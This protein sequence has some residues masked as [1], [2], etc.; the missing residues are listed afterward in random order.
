MVTWHFD[1]VCQYWNH[2]LW[3]NPHFR[4]QITTC[5]HRN[6]KFI[7]FDIQISNCGEMQISN[8]ESRP[9]YRKN[10]LPCVWCGWDPVEFIEF[11]HRPF[12]LGG[13]PPS[14][15]PDAWSAVPGTTTRAGGMV[16][17]RG[18]RSMVQMK[19]SGPGGI[20]GFSPSKAFP[21]TSSDT[22]R[23]NWD[24]NL[25]KPSSFHEF[26]L[27]CLVSCGEYDEKWWYMMNDDT[28]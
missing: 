2:N 19:R 9:I 18:A 25:K 17:K 1:A 22:Q 20:F 11:P 10:I 7:L 13:G 15:H 26:P 6:V 8:S 4:I 14:P 23:F 28:W 24:G 12:H 3:L 21:C 27:V 5:D 16:Q